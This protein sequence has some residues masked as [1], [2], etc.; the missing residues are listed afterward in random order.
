MTPEEYKN[1]PTD[2][3]YGDGSINPYAKQPNV[4]YM[5]VRYN[6]PIAVYIGDVLIAQAEQK[7]SV[8]FAYSFPISF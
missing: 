4:L 6:K 3:Y 5:L 1:L 2:P 8:G 7:G